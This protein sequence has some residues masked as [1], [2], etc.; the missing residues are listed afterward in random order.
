MITFD[1]ALRVL[2]F[3]IDESE[4]ELAFQTWFAQRQKPRSDCNGR[5]FKI[6]RC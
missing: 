1:P 4:A 3:S 6:P 2:P 5:S